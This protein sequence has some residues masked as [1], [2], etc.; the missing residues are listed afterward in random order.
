MSTPALDRLA[1]ARPGARVVV[2]HLIEGGERATDVLGELVELGE[3]EVVVERRG[4]RI[5]IPV[6]DIVVAK[7]VPPAPD[8]WRVAA[9]LRRAGVAVLD[10]DG[11]IRTFDESGAVAAVESRLG[12]GRGGFMGLAFGLPEASAMVVGKARYDEW[13]A[14]LRTRLISDGHAAGVADE[15]I[16]TWTSDHGSAI[17]PT[18]DLVD[19]LLAA[20]TPT[21]VFTNGTD[22]VPTELE[23]IGLGHLLPHLLN[24]ADLGFAKPA[25]ESYAVAHAEIERRLGRRVG[26]GE[27]HFTDDRP[28]NV[29]AA[30]EFG[31]QARVFT[32]P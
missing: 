8:R 14:A 32:L 18:V 16:A 3:V 26:V 19:G 20:G 15:A 1:S 6:A 27:V 10:L 23:Q 30:R 29:D 13:A 7:E 24:A 4:E 5:V 25:P 21:F 11:V 22:R 2:R 9:F 17:A 28:S 31:W 12:L